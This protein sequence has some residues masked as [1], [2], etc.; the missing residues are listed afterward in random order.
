VGDLLSTCGAINWDINLFVKRFPEPGEEVRVLKITRVPGGTAA[1]VAVAAARLLGPGKVAFLGAL[2]DDDIGRT[3]IEILRSEGILADAIR[4]VKGEESGQA[5]IVIEESGQNVIHT[6]F[7]ANLKVDPDYITSEQAR[8]VV[9]RSRVVVIMDPPLE[10]AETLASLAREAGATVIWDPG[11]YVE[12]GLDRLRGAMEDVDYF[13]LNE[14]ETRNLLGSAEPGRVAEI[15]REVSPGSRFIIKLGAKGS[16][17]VDSDTGESVF[18]SGV[19]LEKLGMGVVNTVGCGDAFIGAFA[20]CKYL[21]FDDVDAL[22]RANVAGA[23]KAT[24][25]ETRGSPTRQQLEEMY[26]RSREHIVIERE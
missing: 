1:N 11:V 24:R 5:Y 8:R 4:I 26:E 23:F 19:P 17:I 12:E 21:G 6:Y 18:V 14:I 13:I 25:P 3:Q 15:M 2:G 16:R 9:E 22:V 20:S 7:G 10:A